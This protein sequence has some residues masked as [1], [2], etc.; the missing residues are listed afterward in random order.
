MGEVELYE[1]NLS[2]IPGHQEFGIIK[3]KGENI[4]DLKMVN[5]RV[6]HS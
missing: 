6:Y 1:Q 3:E 2:V 4:D 5:L